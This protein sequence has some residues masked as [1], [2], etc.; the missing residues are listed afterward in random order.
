MW[1]QWL[2][3][4]MMIYKRFWFWPLTKFMHISIITDRWKQMTLKCAAQWAELI[5]CIHMIWWF[6]VHHLCRF[7]WEKHIEHRDTFDN[8]SYGMYTPGHKVFLEIYTIY[9]YIKYTFV[10][11]ISNNNNNSFKEEYEITSDYLNWNYLKCALQ[12]GDGRLF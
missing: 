8:F 12:F 4:I 10:L 2:V 1:T 11:N 7:N 3:K 9:I 6:I 5:C